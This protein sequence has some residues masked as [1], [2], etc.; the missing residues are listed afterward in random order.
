M[1]SSIYPIVEGHGDVPSVSILLRRFASEVFQNNQV[2]IFPAYRIPRGRMVTELHLERA[3]E[4]G[5]RKITE[6]GGIG[7]ILILLDADDDCPAVIG[8]SLLARATQARPDITS[9][10][11]VANKEYEAW[12]LAA[13]IS[14]RGYR[15]ILQN[16]TPPAQ[17]EEIRA[18][19]G[20][21]EREFFETGSCYSERIDQPA[22]TATFA[23][24]ETDV[25]RSFQKLRRDIGALFA[26]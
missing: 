20:Y 13:A 15:N 7:G 25:C 4:L 24:A 26:L 1:L 2:M 21:L 18:A 6:Y 22:L 19:K 11:V 9:K 3:I 12:F 17:P 8:P 5:A 14:L 10:V 23:F 16:A